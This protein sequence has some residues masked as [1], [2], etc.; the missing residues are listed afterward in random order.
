MGAFLI[1]FKAFLLILL[2]FESVKAQI[3]CTEPG[4]YPLGDTNCQYYYLCT[5]DFKLIIFKC[6]D[7]TV[8]DTDKSACVLPTQSTS[9]MITTTANPYQCST[10]GRFPINDPT[11]QK[12]YLC[13]RDTNGYAKKMLK[14]PNQTIFDPRRKLCVLRTSYICGSVTI[15]P[16]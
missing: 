14:C 16:N 11:C 4:R 9:C 2:I 10:S 7:G 13:Y 15:T 1:I 5:E 12:Y 6:P 8:F 3:V